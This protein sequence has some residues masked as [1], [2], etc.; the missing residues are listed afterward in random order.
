MKEKHKCAPPHRNCMLT[1]FTII[2]ESIKEMMHLHIL[3]YIH[4]CI[5]VGMCALKSKCTAHIWRPAADLP[6]LL[7]SNCI[8]F[9]PSSNIPLLNMFVPIFLHTSRPHVILYSSNCSP[10]ASCCHA[11]HKIPH[12][13]ST[14]L[15]F[16]AVELFLA[17]RN[18]IVPLLD[19]VNVGL[20][21]L[22]VG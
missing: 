5:Y 18:T 10:P 19:F 8:I 3:M 13:F 1:P 22:I 16:R 4:V 17:A 9:P 14:I 15:R 7:S 20:K 11:N 12:F 2:Y 21:A 6:S